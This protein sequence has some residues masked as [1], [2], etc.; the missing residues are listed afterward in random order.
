MKKT[1]LLSAM[2]AITGIA[3]AQWTKQNTNFIFESEGVTDFQIINAT[4]VWALG[5]DGSANDA[6]Y[7]DFT[8]TLNGGTTWN[9]GTISLGDPDLKPTNISAVNATTAWVGAVSPTPGVGGGGVW[10]TSDGG[11][12]WT[13]QN[14]TAY[15]TTPDSFFNVVHFFDANTGITQGDPINGAFEMYRTT[16]GGTT[17][18]PIT[19]TPAPA[20]GEYGYNGGNVAA[21]TSFWFVTN[22]GKLYRTTDLGVTWT[23]LTTRI[24]DFGSTAASGRLHFSDNNNGIIIGTTGGVTTLYKTSDGGSNWTT[25]TVYTVPY[26]NVSYV[27]GTSILVGT[28]QTGTGATAVFYSGYSLDNGTTWTQIETTSGATAQQKTTPA[29]FNTTTGWAGGFVGADGTGGIYKFTGNLS[30]SDVI[31]NSVKL[32][33][34]PNPANNVLNLKG[35]S[36]NKV[37]AYDLLGKEV[38]SQD[39]SSQDEVSINVSALKTGMYIL[40]VYNDNGAA[41]TMKFTKE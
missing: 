11:N 25:G 33:A 37:V 38:L 21:G 28:G 31:A 2:F 4:T 9:S 15:T 30:I 12:V 18:T 7:Q 8:R 23:K 29:F 36:I 22:Q 5:Y 27:Q 17:W 41:Q 39:F 19:G 6:V 10:K 13:Q 26:T 32:V 24:S 1:L 14:A 40:N 35:A 34:Y 16:N 20:A 3:N